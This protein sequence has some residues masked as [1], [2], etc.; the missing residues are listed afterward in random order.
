MAT[1]I[2]R[3]QTNT[4]K[5]DIS[6]YCIK[7]SVAAVG[8]SLL[9][10]PNR[11]ELRNLE[12]ENYCEYAGQYYD[13]YGSVS[14]LALEVKENDI[15]WL[16]SGGD[17]Y[18]ARVDKIS[19]WVFNVD[20]EAERLDA[21]NQLTNIEWIKA[22]DESDVPG[23]LTTAFIRGSTL[24]RIYKPGICEYSEF[25]YNQKHGGNFYKTRKIELTEENFYSLISPTDC[26]DLLYM[27]LYS[28]HG[29]NY[30]C[31]P[32]TN[33]AAT[34]KYE[35]VILDAETGKH[36][37]LQVKNGEVPLDADDYYPKVQGT[38]NEFYLLTT[39]GQVINADKYPNRIIP[40]C[41]TVLFEFACNEEN[42]NL[43]PPNI[44]YWM[45]FIGDHT[46]LSGRKGIMFDTESEDSE[47]RMLERSVVAA[48]GGPKRYIRSF[49]KGDYVFYY[50]KGCGIIAV[51]EVVS[52]QPRSIDSDSGLELNVKIL[53]DR[54]LNKHGEVAASIPAA[55]IK[56]TLGKKFFFASTRKVPFLDEKES[57]VLISLMQRKTESGN[58]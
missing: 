55:E 11:Y 56:E 48:W 1:T 10:Y 36:I 12:F 27:W 20:E 45:E 13:S 26:E 52:D 47:K 58:R 6:E 50:K 21:C 19:K 49:S 51:G 40:V 7:N 22:G 32:S 42:Q 33:K 23:A 44:K 31:I 39:R 28:T 25:L 46:G 14:R 54:T 4:S 2:W 30:V 18:F 57:Q 24:Q 38:D 16:R 17:Y 37:Y 3:L 5:G 43:I 41:P 8:W 29:K 53:I 9:N 34:P 35:F 15:L